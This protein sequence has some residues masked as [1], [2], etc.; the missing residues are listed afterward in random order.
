MVAESARETGLGIFFVSP[1]VSLPF[2]DRDQQLLWRIHLKFNEKP[3][4]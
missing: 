1:V 2:A 4:F 3:L